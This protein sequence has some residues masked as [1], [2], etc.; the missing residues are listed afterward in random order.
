MSNTVRRGRADWR[1]LVA[2]FEDSDLSLQ[3]FAQRHGLRSSTLGWWRWELQR[4]E[5]AVKERKE[6]KEVAVVEF[7]RVESSVS[8]AAARPS[9]EAGPC[10]ELPGGVLLHFVAGTTAAFVAA[11]AADT[12]RHLRGEVSR[13]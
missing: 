6:Q 12:C 9:T 13:C 5:G 1:R 2:E 3:D 7:V 4:E 11:V 8:E 10:L